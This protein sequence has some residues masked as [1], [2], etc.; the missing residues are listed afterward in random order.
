M[1]A[2]PHVSAPAETVGGASPWGHDPR[3]GRAEKS[4]GRKG[5]GSGRE[6][7]SRAALHIINKDP[8]PQMGWET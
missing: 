6:G 2:G 7:K 8:T 4:E 5:R 1:G 3:E